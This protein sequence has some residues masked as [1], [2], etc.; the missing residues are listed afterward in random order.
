LNPGFRAAYANR[1][2]AYTTMREYEKSIADSR[3]AVE[4]EPGNPS[5][6]LEY[7]SIGGALQRLNRNDAAYD[8]FDRAIELNPGY[9]EGLNNR[10]V[11][12]VWR[13][14][15]AGAVA[16]F[17]RAIAANPGYRDA[18]SNRAIAYVRMHE[19]EKSMA[20]RR[21]ALGL[22]KEARN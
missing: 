17:S 3:R 19:Y 2:I 7:G 1:A 6:Y 22:A 14:D 20:D 11:I 4:L 13:G 9:A 12:K 21:R 8:A 5:N 15:L 16:D 18:Y 10:G